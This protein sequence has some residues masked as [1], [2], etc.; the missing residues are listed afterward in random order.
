MTRSPMKRAV[1]LALVAAAAIA[2]ALLPQALGPFHIRVLQFFFFAAA[3]A[4]AWNILGGFAGYWSFGHTVS[5][6]VGAFSAAHFGL[7]F[8]QAEGPWGM[9]L[10]LLAGGLVSGVFALIIA[11][12]LLRLRGTYFAIAML[13]VSQVVAELANNLSVFQGGVGLF[14]P[15]PVPSGMAPERFYYYAFAALLAL[16]LGVSWAVKRSKFGYALLSIRE[17][18]D[19]AQMLGVA[20]ERYKIAA[21]VLSASL[22]GLLGAVYGYSLGYFTTYSV[23]RLDFSLNM[24]V[25]CLIG[26]IGT[27]FGPVIGAALLLFL[28]NVLLSDFLDIH[29][30]LTGALVVATILLMP[31]GILRAGATLP[32]KRRARKEAKA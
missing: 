31:G 9:V 16:C 21:F 2:V 12:P 3:T 6:G 10:P 1:A 7:I 23:F 26:G 29:L 28:T 4:V 25:F 32:W 8:G 22:V 14:L 18:E 17:D 11:Y 5:I 30:M 15:S 20:T 13:G 27:L 19:T 24:I